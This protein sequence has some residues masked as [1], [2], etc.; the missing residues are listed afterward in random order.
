MFSSRSELAIEAS[1]T[2][3]G[4]PRSRIGPEPLRKNCEGTFLKGFH[5]LGVHVGYSHHISFA[6]DR[7][8]SVKRLTHA[9]PV[10][11][12]ERERERGTGR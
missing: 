8:R 9:T 4:G 6:E 7:G 10:V 12:L 1:L 2:I 11:N 5:Q 3:L